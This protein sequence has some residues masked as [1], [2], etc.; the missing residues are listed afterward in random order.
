MSRPP[1]VLAVVGAPDRGKSSIVATLIEDPTVEIRPEA[2]TTRATNAFPMV[3]DGETLFT[4]LD[5][6]G[7][8]EADALLARIENAT[9]HDHERAEA[10]AALMK[11]PPADGEFEKEAEILRP[12]IDGAIVL[13]VVDVDRSYRGDR[14]PEMKLLRYT[15]R[16]R[17]A[18]LNREGNAEN[19]EGWR[20]VLGQY[21]AVVRDFD[22]HLAGFG[23]RIALLRTI[24][25]LVPEHRETIDRAIMAMTEERKRRALDAAGA[26]TEMLID[27][28]SLTIEERADDDAALT[29]QA[30]RIEARFHEVL[31]ARE[32]EARRAV[33]RL[34][35]HGAAFD[36]AGHSPP[37]YE[38]DLFAEATWDWF[39]LS[40]SALVGT[41]SAAGAITGALIDANVGGA[42]FGAG[43]LLGTLGGAGLAAYGLRER[44]MTVKLGTGEG[45]FGSGR[46]TSKRYRIGPHRNDNFGFVLLDRAIAH[47]RDVRTRAHARQDRAVVGARQGLSDT[48]GVAE[49]RA[50]LSLFQDARK[51]GPTPEV[52]KDLY[53]R[54]CALIAADE[55][56]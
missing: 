45:P 25:E 10:L 39:G 27:S 2:G 33:E 24:A 53:T 3:V 12:I 40:S 44:L 52:R 37:R 32:G 49:R 47:L 26:I 11:A 51:K 7:F 18:L 9:P 6:P 8:E 19:R 14:I 21:F 38:Q 31:R 13:Y 1:L 48:L 20:P 28:L 50:L 46:D 41:A 4:V 35:K 23:E 29:R 30:A 42:S 43:L 36:E 55:R 22:A 15:G 17:M 56:G 34:Y 16:P 54:L 5:T